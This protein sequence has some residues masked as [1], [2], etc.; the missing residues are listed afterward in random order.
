MFVCL[1]NIIMHGVALYV[2]CLGLP[3]YVLIVLFVLFSIVLCVYACVGY[4]WYA[5]CCFVLVL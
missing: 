3:G 4:L 1:F 5:L 2:L